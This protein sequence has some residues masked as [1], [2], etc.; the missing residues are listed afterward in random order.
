VTLR[1][2]SI[3]V[4][5]PLAVSG[6]RLSAGERLV[7]N[8]KAGQLRVEHPTSSENVT[9]RSRETA[10]TG[11]E[12]APRKA[13]PPSQARTA[14]PV[15]GRSSW[16]K[17][18]AAGDFDGVLAEAQ[19]SGLD[20]T[21]GRATLPELV[22]LADAARYRGR[23]DVAR[24]TLL[25]QRER[26]PNSTAART[27]AFLL[28]RLAESIPETAID[29]YDR[30]LGEAP[31]GEFASEALGRKFLAVQRMSG[32]AAARPIATEYL[33]RFPRG[34]YATQARELASP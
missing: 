31:N 7:A 9:E 24:R 19:E 11:E 33:R 12:E 23:A 16:A 13:E 27:A 20:A 17:R 25:A 29:W 3:V 4:K 22:A 8:L 14:A 1:S 18:V 2:G 21:F 28:G 5:G 34:A 6:I 30:Y 15:E 10:A 26:F 32:A